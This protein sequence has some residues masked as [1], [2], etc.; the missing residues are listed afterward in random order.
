MTVYDTWTA[1]K[2][3]NEE[4]SAHYNEVMCLQA[5]RYGPNSIP[6]KETSFLS[7]STKLTERKNLKYLCVLPKGHKGKCQH[8]FTSFFKKT[9]EAKKVLKSIDCAIYS[10]PGN[11][12]YVYKNRASRIHHSVLSNNEE[13]KIRDKKIKKKCAI[14]LKDATTP[15]FLAQAAFDWITYLI[16]V[17]GVSDIL[18]TNKMSYFSD[19]KQFL[20]NYYKGFDRNV[21]DSE[22]NTICCVTR[23]KLKI[24]DVFDMERDMRTAIRDTDL[25]MGHNIPRSEEYITIRGCNLLPM[26]RRGNLL[27]GEKKFTENKWIEELKSVVAPY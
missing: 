11:D 4:V 12:D 6:E 10:T 9:P 1:S 23:H 5:T 13:K 16:S 8:K 26:T 17:P 15:L 7:E 20:E 3:Q 25:Q 21:F 18:N 19:H 27:I 14:P 24:T 2:A 22:G